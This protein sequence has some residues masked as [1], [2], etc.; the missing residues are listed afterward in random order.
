MVI[1]LL[2][3]QDLTPMV[4]VRALFTAV[5]EQQAVKRNGHYDGLSCCLVGAV[6]KW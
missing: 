3:N 4:L 2:V 1:P 6:A 5:F